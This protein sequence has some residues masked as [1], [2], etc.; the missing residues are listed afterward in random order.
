MIN[1]N[2][3]AKE[4]FDFYLEKFENAGANTPFDSAKECALATVNVMEQAARSTFVHY[5]NSAISWS[6]SRMFDHYLE[7]ISIISKYE[8][9]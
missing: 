2:Q 6:S 5:A 7:M 9:E 1:A 3:K 8:K 4:I